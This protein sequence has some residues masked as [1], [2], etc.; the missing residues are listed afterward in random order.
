MDQIKVTPA[1]AAVVI[2]FSLLLF[3]LK[4]WADGEAFGTDAPTNIVVTPAGDLAVVVGHEM[5]VGTPDKVETIYDLSDF[6]APFVLGDVRFFPNG[7]LLIRQGED[8]RSF[9]HNLR[10]YG[11]DDHRGEAVLEE[12]GTLAR[13]NLTT[14]DCRPVAPNLRFPTSPFWVEIDPK[15]E[16]LFVSA[17]EEHRIFKYAPDGTLLAMQ[18]RGLAFPNQLLLRDGK[19]YNANT[20]YNEIAILDPSTQGFGKKLQTVSV[21]GLVPTLDDFTGVIWTLGLAPVGDEWWVLVKGDGMVGGPILRFD[22]DWKFLA[23]IELP[24]RSDTM[25]LTVFGDRVVVADIELRRVLQFRPDG[26]A[27]PDLA[28]PELT[29]RLKA[30]QARNA[31]YNMVG[32]NILFGFVLLFLGLLLWAI[33]QKRAMEAAAGAVGTV[34]PPQ[35]IPALAEKVTLGSSIWLALVVVIA[36]MIGVLNLIGLLTVLFVYFL[37]DQSS[38]ILNWVSALA[39]LRVVFFFWLGSKV[40]KRIEKRQQQPT[41]P[42][43]PPA[44]TAPKTTPSTAPAPRATIE[45]PRSRQGRALGH[46]GQKAQGYF[47]AFAVLGLTILAAT[48]LPDLGENGPYF[49]VGGAIVSL[50]IFWM[51]HRRSHHLASKDQTA[52]HP[53]PGTTGF[54]WIGI[55]TWQ[56]RLRFGV[57]TGLFLVWAWIWAWL[58]IV[59]VTRTTP[60]GHHEI[61]LMALAISTLIFATHFF[62]T[63]LYRLGVGDGQVVMLH[64]WNRTSVADFDQIILSDQ[65]IQVGDG[66]IHLGL[67]PWQEIA[68]HLMP[69]MARAKRVPHRE[70]RR[71]WWRDNGVEVMLMLALGLGGLLLFA[72]Y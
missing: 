54:Y 11:R 15:D 56:R 66:H 24:E 47:L 48:R 52:A 25:A 5:L 2:A 30:A 14:K 16:T 42:A 31:F 44:A 35:P 17:P 26:A 65:A 53:Q 21:K 36:W 72:V 23:P 60:V 63:A 12:V 38:T 46:F 33:K 41:P 8:V 37:I 59:E 29:A 20:N 51:T 13:C 6:G 27:L 40:L 55:E 3:G 18:D 10:A 45:D 68:R 34:G 64:P 62:K 50:L 7:E 49:I 32:S 28:W 69:K 19:L 67:F 39:A 9:M 22:Q 58:G 43:P 71:L 57:A 1:L 70:M 61:P 4:F